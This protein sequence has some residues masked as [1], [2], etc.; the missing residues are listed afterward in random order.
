MTSSTG[1]CSGFDGKVEYAF[2]A[3]TAG[4]YLYF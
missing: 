3:L 2:H 4:I 1:H